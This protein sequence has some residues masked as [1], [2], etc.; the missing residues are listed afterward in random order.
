MQFGISVDIDGDRAVVGSP[1]VGEPPTTGAVHV[2]EWSGSAWTLTH[3][4]TPTSPAAYGL[5][6][7]SVALEG[8]RL[9]VGGFDRSWVFHHSGGTWNQIQTLTGGGLHDNTGDISGDWI[10]TGSSGDD[11]RGHDAG[12]ARIYRWN[13]VDWVLWEQLYAPDA[14]HGHRFGASVALDGMRAIVGAEESDAGEIAL[15][16]AAYVVDWRIDEHHYPTL[17]I[18]DGAYHTAH[19]SFRLGAEGLDFEADGRPNADAT[20]DDLSG[21]DDEHGVTFTSILVPGGAGSLEV[22]A[23]A[24]GHLD[25][26][27]DFNGDGD[28]DDADE[29]ILTSVPLNAGINTLGYN[30]PTSAV[31]TS[32]TEPTFARFRLSSTG[33]LTPGGHAPDGEVEDYAVHIEDR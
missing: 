27:I 25:A 32:Q 19:P 4:I 18:N 16:G 21:I 24:P 8:E 33:G 11:D 12:A 15:S 17:D 20:G 7:S 6:G 28:W 1:G 23:T 14:D 5:F 30:I 13:G 26:W 3:E 9:V 10:V 29:Q 31:P 22:F 2:F